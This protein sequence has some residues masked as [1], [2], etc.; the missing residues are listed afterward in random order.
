MKDKL[1]VN[2]INALASVGVDFDWQRLQ[3]LLQAERLRFSCYPAEGNEFKAFDRLSP[4]D[5]K[6]VICGQDPYHGPGQADGLA[7]SVGPGVDWPPSLKNIVRE[8]ESDLQCQWPVESMWNEQG[9]LAH[10]I[11]EGVLLLNDVLTVRAGDA[12]SH[13]G[14]GW[15]ELTSGIFRALCALEQPMVFILWGKEAQKKA[16]FVH[17][18]EHLVLESA[19]P[20]PLAAYRG[21]WGS[22]PFSRSNE[23]FKQQGCAPVKW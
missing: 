1:N 8:F 15:Q 9:A 17:R 10:W 6:V 22:K 19:H 11:D 4:K 2:W 14:L 21:F 20:S 23:W 5:V 16:S 12:A 18:A 13:H 7:F 3:H